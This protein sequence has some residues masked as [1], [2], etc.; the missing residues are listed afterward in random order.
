LKQLASQLTE[1]HQRHSKIAIGTNAVGFVGAALGV[2]GAVALVTPAGPAILLAA[3]ATQ[4]TSGVLQGGHAIAKKMSSKDANKLADR[5]L[6]WY[7]LCLS[8]LQ[9]LEAL[10]GDLI[11]QR[12]ELIVGDDWDMS[13]DS[14]DLLNALLENGR[15]NVSTSDQALLVWKTLSYGTYQTTRQGLTG[16]AISAQ[17]GATHA[18]L[19][20]STI[21]AVPV[22][23][24]AFSVGCM[25]MD[26]G[27][28]ASNLGKMQKPHAKA[29]ALSGVVIGFPKFIGPSIQSEVEALVAALT[30][31]RNKQDEVRTRK[32]HN[33]IEQEL[34]NL[35]M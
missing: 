29:V 14:T 18:Q 9:A 1:H 12:T 31:L 20:A 6:G 17:M 25:A 4:A 22:V 34:V 8:I 5:C 13:T 19:I 35:S 27:N 21:Q 15:R 7:G 16:V 23:G 3:I 26:A 32:E 33:L 24:A 28:I 10:R 30:E 2:A 11:W